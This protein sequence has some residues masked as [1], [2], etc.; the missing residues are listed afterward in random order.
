M[1]TPRGTAQKWLAFGAVVVVAVG[2]SFASSAFKAHLK[3]TLPAP[4][5]PDRHPPSA[6]PLPPPPPLPAEEIDPDDHAPPAGD[7]PTKHVGSASSSLAARP[8]WD[9]LDPAFPLDEATTRWAPS[10]HSRAAEVFADASAATAA[11]TNAFVVCQGRRDAGSAD[12]HMSAKLGDLPEVAANASASSAVYVSAPHVTLEADDDVDVTLFVRGPNNGVSQLLRLHRET[13]DGLSSH[14][15]RSSIECRAL[16]GEALDNRIAADAGRA[17][18]ATARVAGVRI[19]TSKLWVV[20]ES[21]VEVRRMRRRIGDV[22]ALAG[23]DDPRVKKRV[24]AHDAAV[25]R[26]AAEERRAFAEL[27]RG[28]TKETTVAGMKIAVLGAARVGDASEVE[29][30]LTN[31]GLSGRTFAFP[32]FTITFL[33]DLRGTPVVSTDATM[34]GVSVSPNERA[35]VVVKS[36]KVLLA[37]AT[38][39]QVCHIPANAAPCGVIRLR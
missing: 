22:A 5:N 31:E 14:E 36:R 27:Q 38:L 1:K 15:N 3:S 28:A 35:T 19:D 25:A 6:A 24:K 4:A 13:R 8:A 30:A 7:P 34:E 10:D 18:S 39:A 17:D 9:V 12:L 21:R 11:L 20:R 29:L 33:S 37:G 32:D 16:E 2:V 23:W 26:L